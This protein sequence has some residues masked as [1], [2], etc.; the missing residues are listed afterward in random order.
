[1]GLP[2]P[3]DNYNGYQEA[4]LALKANLFGDNR[5]MVVHGTADDN[6]HIQHTM[7]LSKALIKSGVIFRQ[8]VT[9]NMF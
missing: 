4:N 6:V 9:Y 1:M 8:Q 7:T 2:T 3:E 5:L